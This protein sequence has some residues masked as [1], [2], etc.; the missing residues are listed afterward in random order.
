V[1]HV[2]DWGEEFVSNCVIKRDLKELSNGNGTN[3]IDHN[4]GDDK[5]LEV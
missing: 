2:W 3:H 4:Q 5:E 1:L